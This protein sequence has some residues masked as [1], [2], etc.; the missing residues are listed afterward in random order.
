MSAYAIGLFR[1]AEL[2][3]ELVEYLEKLQAT[4]DPYSG[5]FLVHGGDMES[6]EGTLERDVVLIEF[7]SLEQAR[8]WYHSPAYQEILPLRTRHIDGDAFLVSGVPDGYN[9]QEKAEVF[10]QLLSEDRS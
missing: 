2:H 4:L 9:P 8:D 5:K 1:T 3:H 6:Y 7:P 10:R